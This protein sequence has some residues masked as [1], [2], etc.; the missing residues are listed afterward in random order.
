MNPNPPSMLTLN[1]EQAYL[2]TLHDERVVSER[3]LK[4]YE[5]DSISCSSTGCYIG[6]TQT[7]TNRGYVAQLTHGRLGT[8][9]PSVLPGPRIACE[10]ATCVGVSGNKIAV[11]HHGIQ[12]SLIGT[13]GVQAY[14]GVG[15]GPGL[16]YAAVGA[17]YHRAGSIL[18][19]G[20][21]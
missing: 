13:R 19:T 10:G 5:F 7:T 21:A 14:E 4:G 15:I 1:D 18:T 16:S 3:W 20:T 9:N 17:R 11:Y 6:L 2:I 12:Q 8:L